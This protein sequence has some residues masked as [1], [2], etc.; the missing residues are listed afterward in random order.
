[1]KL[2]SITIALEPTYSSNNPGK[3]TAQIKYQSPTEE[4]AI[5]LTEQASLELLAFVGPLVAR[6]AAEA[7]AQAAGW[8]QEAVQQAQSK[9]LPAG[10]VTVISETPIER[11]ETP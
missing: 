5:L 11:E 7:A 1:M 9:L 3:W 4:S 6:R 8:I 10:S 2:Q